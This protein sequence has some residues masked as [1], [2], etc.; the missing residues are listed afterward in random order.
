M[1]VSK[2]ERIE[3]NIEELVRANAE[4]VQNVEALRMEFEKETWFKQLK[5][6]TDWLDEMIWMFATTVNGR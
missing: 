3:R 4:V 6:N 5:R 1:R 2:K